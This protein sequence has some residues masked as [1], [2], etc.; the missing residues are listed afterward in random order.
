M[1][2]AATASGGRTRLAGPAEI[3]PPDMAGMEESWVQ[4]AE[5]DDRNPRR[6]SVSGSLVKLLQAIMKHK[7]AYPFKRPVTEKEAPDYKEIVKNPMDFST[8][9][10]RI[11]S[12]A[13]ADVEARTLRR[14]LLCRAPL[15][16]HSFA[17]QI[18][19]RVRSAS[20]R[21]ASFAVDVRSGSRRGL[22]GDPA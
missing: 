12:G 2:Y 20:A 13:V 5:E 16:A 15:A 4:L 3:V 10:S 11:M 9:R 21:G 8:L 18:P 22:R 7:W 6:V 17:A 14:A 1:S 19:S